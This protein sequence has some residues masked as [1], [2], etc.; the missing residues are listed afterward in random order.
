MTDEKKTLV[1]AVP[2]KSPH[3]FQ[4]YKVGIPSE[5]PLITQ[6]ELIPV[7]KNKEFKAAPPPDPAKKKASTNNQR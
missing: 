2:E 5:P 1:K 3:V 6:V 7:A 4:G